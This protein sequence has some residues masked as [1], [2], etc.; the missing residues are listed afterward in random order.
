VSVGYEL[1][2]PLVAL[3]IGP[4]S[5]K[6]E[7][8][9]LGFTLHSPGHS[10]WNGYGMGG[11]HEIG[12]GFHGIGDGF[13]LHGHIFH[14]MC[15]GFHLHSTPS[16]HGH[17]TFIPP[18]FHLHSMVIPPSFHPHST[19]IPPSFH[20]HSMAI[21]PSFH[22]HSTFIPWS[23][24]MESDSMTCFICNLASITPIPS[25]FHMDSIWIP[26]GMTLLMGNLRSIKHQKV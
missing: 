25:S 5:L 3:V 21:P 16:F 22:G 14:G 10:T 26:Y 7:E 19:F 24:H 20:P 4:T 8:G 9:L 18:S 13:H 12:Y 11:I 2:H 15:D 6:R 17:S 1:G 23:F